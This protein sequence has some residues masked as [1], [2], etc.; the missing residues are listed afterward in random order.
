LLGINPNNTSALKLRGKCYIILDNFNGALS[1]FNRIL[2]II[3]NDAYALMYRGVIYI[4][5]GKREEA[6][7]NLNNSLKIEPGNAEALVYR[8]LIYIELSRYDEASFDLNI[9]FNGNRLIIPYNE[10][11]DIRILN[12]GGFG[13][14]YQ[15]IWVNK[16]GVERKVALKYLKSSKGYSVDIINEI[17][18]HGLIHRDLHSKN[19][20]ICKNGDQ[21]LIKIGDFGLTTFANVPESK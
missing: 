1:D 4:K 19:I 13:K 11:Q 20:L 10:L 18:E 17:H 9:E 21:E 2:E 16:L 15:A 3:P 5:L 7:S 12:E 8:G 14:I 6:L